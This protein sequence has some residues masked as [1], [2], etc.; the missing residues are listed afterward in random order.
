MTQFC[1]FNQAGIHG[2]LI[3]PLVG[4]LVVAGAAGE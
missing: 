4:Q 3:P 1:V 2:A